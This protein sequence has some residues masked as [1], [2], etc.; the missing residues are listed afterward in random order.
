MKELPK[1]IVVVHVKNSDQAVLQTG[2][3]LDNGA[4]GVFLIDHARPDL[5]LIETYR[6][7]R[8]SFQHAWLGLNLLGTQ[9]DKA[10]AL[11]PGDAD[12]LWLD[13]PED[14]TAE[15]LPE[16]RNWRV[17][18]GAAF[19]Y[20][21]ALNEPPAE[22]VRVASAFDEAD[23]V[24]TS[25]EATGEA[26]DIRKVQGMKQALGKRLLALASGVAIDNVRDYLSSVDSFLVASSISSDFHTLEPS[27]VRALSDVIH[28][29]AAPA[30][31]ELSLDEIQSLVSYH[32]EL[33]TRYNR[34]ASTRL[35]AK[36][37]ACVDQVRARAEKHHRRRKELSKFLKDGC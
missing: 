25:G 13:N 26:A 22:A 24:T 3:A 32:L 6:R 21:L 20:Q 31:V 14:L 28:G 7:V 33:E 8:R 29:R 1:F 18:A 35:A 17:F 37:D 23:V 19:K 36:S 11:I 12:G 30:A 16:D 4:D 2:V 15:E 5:K 34:E 27:K 10:A 9:P